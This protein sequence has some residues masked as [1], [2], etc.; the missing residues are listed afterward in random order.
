MRTSKILWFLPILILC[1][2][3]LAENSVGPA[4]LELYRGKQAEELTK[5]DRA[6]DDIYFRGETTYGI[7]SANGWFASFDCDVPEILTN[8]GGQATAGFSNAGD[9]DAVDQSYVYELTN[10]NEF[11]TYNLVTGAYTALAP[12]S[13][14]GYP[15]KTWVAMALD[16]T[17]GI[18][19]AASTDLSTSDLYTIDPI[20]AT[21]SLVGAIGQ[22]GVISLAVDGD[23]N[24]W[25]HDLVNDTFLSIDKA[26]GAG[27]VVGPLGFDANF[28]QGMTLNPATGDILMAAFNNT[29]FQPQLRLVDT[30]TGSSTLIGVLG[31]TAPGGLCQ[32]GWIAIPGEFEPPIYC[33]ASGGNDEWIDGVE[34]EEIVNLTNGYNTGYEDFTDMVANVTQGE[35]Y[36]I[37]IYTGNYYTSDDYGVWIDFNR[38]YD[39]YD[40][41][42]NVVCVGGMG[43]EV[44]TF[45]I[46]IPTGVP[47]GNTR[48]RVRLKYSGADCGDPCGATTYGEVEDYTVHIGPPPS[49][50]PA[51]GGNDEYID[52]VELN[53]IS[54]LGN[55]YTTGYEDFTY[56]STDLVLAFSY[57]ITIHTGNYWTSDDYA[58]W[59]D[60]NHDYDFYDAG[61]NVVCV[62]DVGAPVNTFNFTV[63]ADAM[64][65]ETRMRVR[66]KY[67]GATCGDPCGDTTFGEVEDYTVNIGG[68]P[69]D[70]G[71]IEGIVTLS[72]GGGNVEDVVVTAG[73][74]SVNPNDT[75]FYS[76]A[77]YPGTY[78]VDAVLEG[79][80]PDGEDNVV[81][82]ENNVTTVD[83][84]LIEI[85]PGALPLLEN[86]DEG[87]PFTWEVVDYLNDGHTW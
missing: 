57:D 55:G 7:E 8:L 36:D 38:D 59:I 56:L 48:M 86:F 71:F 47:N 18:M 29:A 85:I 83:L 69:P 46:T 32:F 16:V 79:Y 11:G 52:G 3:L 1:G 9:F 4:P 66:M 54:N 43:A 62:P 15:G 81:V 24:M 72:G 28:G 80:Y 22:P 63:P 23:G 39:F 26:T 74:Q 58:V 67:S 73:G 70:F 33:E 76:I 40:A 27:T 31:A 77:L 78:D 30:A 21:C 13:P 20:A 42:E 61:E 34:F 45:S 51:S 37:T 19:Y 14:N 35:T 84:T 65:G 6:Y 5:A 10:S 2:T 53:T 68:E 17:T 60:F 12:I 82:T 50:C 49:Y 87:I 41:G 25:S 75:G 44:N 64:T